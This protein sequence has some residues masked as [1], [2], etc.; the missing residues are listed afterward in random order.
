MRLRE[1]ESKL[2]MSRGASVH[3][4]EAFITGATQGSLPHLAGSH[5]RCLYQFT[6][7]CVYKMFRMY[8]MMAQEISV[9]LGLMRCFSIYYCNVA[10]W[11]RIFRAL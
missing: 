1:G 2:P 10:Y 5:H 6:S 4:Q 11:V 7:V 8:F 9:A 3:S